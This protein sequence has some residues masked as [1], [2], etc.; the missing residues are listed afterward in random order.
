ML[1]LTCA[2]ALISWTAAL[3]LAGEWSRIDTGADPGPRNG[4]AMAHDGASDRVV[5]MGGHAQEGG[6]QGDLWA[7]D[8]AGWQQLTTPGGPSARWNHAASFDG[9]GVLLIGGEDDS[10]GTRQLL[11]DSWRLQESWTAEDEDGPRARARHAMAYDSL[12]DRVV[13]FGGSIVGDTGADTW[14]WD[15]GSARW[16]ELS[17]SGPP[18][19]R[20]HAMA[21]DGSR[22]ILFGGLADGYLGDT[23]AFDG[24]SWERVA[25]GPSPRA[26]HAMAGGGGIVVAFG[27]QGQDTIY[28]DTWVWNGGAW[29]RVAS[30]DDGPGRRFGHAMVWTG[31]RVV[32]FGGN[33]PALDAQTWGYTPDADEVPPDDTGPDDGGNDDDAG[34]T[35]GGGDADESES[36]GCGCRHDGDEERRWAG[37]LIVLPAF[38]PRRRRSPEGTSCAS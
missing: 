33:T 25:D 14:E 22:V 27:G 18:P 11:G 15:P 10:T 37:L 29:K 31:D 19:R 6:A 5:L 17:V 35:D 26:G 28:G 21:F 3:T 16:T 4:F 32:L 34:E 20:D 30:E 12:R 8:A 7:L 24:S 1:G 9:T 2:T 13:L 36:G 23:W 38:V